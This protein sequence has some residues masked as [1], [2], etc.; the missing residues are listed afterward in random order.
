[1]LVHRLPSYKT[2]DYIFTELENMHRN[3]NTIAL[4]I[5]E[6]LEQFPPV[7]GNQLR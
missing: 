5:V 4:E 7:K 2:A 3:K 6:E 1:L